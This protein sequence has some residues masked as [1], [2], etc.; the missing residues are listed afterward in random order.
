MPRTNHWPTI[1]R[2]ITDS[3]LW[4]RPRV[5][6]TAIASAQND[7]TRAHR[8][9]RR[10]R[11]RA[12]TVVSTIARA[13]AI[14][15]A[16]DADREQRSDQRGPQV[17]LRVIDAADLQIGDQRL[18]DEAEALRPAR[19]RADHGRRREQ[20][21]HPPVR[22]A[23]IV[24]CSRACLF[25]HRCALPLA[26]PIMTT[27]LIAAFVWLG[28]GRVRRP[29]RRTWPEFRGPGGQGHSAERGLPLEWSETKNVAWKTPVR[30]SRLVVAGR[31][32]RPR[33]AHDGGRADA[34]SRCARSPSTSRRARKSSTSRSSRSRPI[35]A[36][37]I[38]R[39]A[40]PRRRR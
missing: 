4:P 15:E 13:E 33:V 19:Q 34:A 12:T 32:Q 11:A 14:D 6:V 28:A 16:A 20:Q 27:L 3:A 38:R 39:T 22:H 36:T 26:D 25:A 5:S 7:C 40:G 31:R 29:R 9:R 35:A 21:H 23:V 30:R 17:Q 8:A 24:G 2:L 1:A 37:S 10:C 18:G